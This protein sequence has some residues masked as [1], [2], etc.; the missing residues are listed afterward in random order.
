MK[1]ADKRGCPPRRERLR[2]CGNRRPSVR[3]A[4]LS[5]S[6]GSML[7]VHFLGTG[8]ALP[9][10][11]RDNTSLAVDDG[12]SVTLVDASGSPLKRL[13]EAGV[14]PDRLARVIITHQ[15]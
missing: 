9:G 10:P 15:H 7:T 4:G 3:S 1:G 6:E 11:G 13:R 14:D 12:Q 2:G 8:A 5:S